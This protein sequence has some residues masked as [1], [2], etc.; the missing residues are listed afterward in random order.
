MDITVLQCNHVLHLSKVEHLRVVY[1]A[2]RYSLTIVPPPSKH[3]T[4]VYRLY[5]VGIIHTRKCITFL[6]DLPRKYEY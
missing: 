6:T 4:F 1:I 5:N 2:N 3:K